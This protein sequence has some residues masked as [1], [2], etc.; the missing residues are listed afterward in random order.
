MATI[1]KDRSIKPG[2][3]DREI[4]DQLR[5]VLTMRDLRTSRV[6]N[7]MRIDSSWLQINSKLRNLLFQVCT[8][9]L[10]PCPVTVI[11]DQ[12]STSK[13][14]KRD[15]SDLRRRNLSITKT[16]RE[17]QDRLTKLYFIMRRSKLTKEKMRP[18]TC[19]TVSTKSNM[20]K[21]WIITN[22]KFSWC[23]MLS[24]R[25]TSSFSQMPF[26][27]SRWMVTATSK[28]LSPWAWSQDSHFNLW[29]KTRWWKKEVSW[30]E[31][32]WISKI[33]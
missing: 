1:K 17:I 24:N 4:R 12:L 28:H 7:S 29:I 21:L 8:P 30:P 32:N 19:M 27:R 15:P 3:T 20:A 23:K 25:K 5:R 16:W 18:S 2:S 22:P 33:W 11:W 13:I 9:L 14:W 26:T 31:L 6:T 10:T